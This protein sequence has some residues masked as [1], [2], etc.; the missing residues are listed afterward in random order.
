MVRGSGQSP[1][2]SVMILLHLHGLAEIQDGQNRE[3][4]GLDRPDEQVER[5]PD[6][7]GQPHDVRREERDQCDQDAAGKNIA[8]ESK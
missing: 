4:E 5:F 6:R 2:I 3:D 8:E 7:V 1:A